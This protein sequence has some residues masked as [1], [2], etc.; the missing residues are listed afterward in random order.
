[1]C[2]VAHCISRNCGHHWLI[3]QV[4]CQPGYG[5]SYCSWFVD[6]V[7]RQPAPEFEM[8]GRCPACAA[9]DGYDRNLIRMVT[10]IRERCRWGAGPSRDDP[11]VECVM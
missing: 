11:G 8:L 7:A 9:P 4:P 1:M 5:F 3:I 2:L 6:G 10:G